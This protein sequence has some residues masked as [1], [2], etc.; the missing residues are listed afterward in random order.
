MVDDPH[1]GLE[2]PRI[3]VDQRQAPQVE[4]DRAGKVAGGEILGGT[5]IDDKRGAVARERAV[6]VRGSR[7][8]V[9]VRI[10]GHSA[11]VLRARAT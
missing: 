11:I 5:Q 1:E 3:G 4:M 8:Q 7:E 6:E 9:R 2:R 10:T